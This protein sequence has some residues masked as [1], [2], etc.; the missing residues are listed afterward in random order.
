MSQT[1]RWQLCAVLMHWPFLPAPACDTSDGFCSA[2]GKAGAGSI[3]GIPS[4]LCATLRHGR[5]SLG[6]LHWAVL[7]T[8][9]QRPYWGLNTTKIVDAPGGNGAPKGT[10]HVLSQLPSPSCT[11][12]RAP[13][14]CTLLGKCQEVKKNCLERRKALKEVVITYGWTAPASPRAEGAAPR[15]PR[16]GSTARGMAW[17][18]WG[19]NRISVHCFYLELSC[20]PR[21]LGEV[22]VE[23]QQSRESSFH[24]CSQWNKVLP[25]PWRTACLLNLHIYATVAKLWWS[26]QVFTLEQ[27]WKTIWTIPGPVQSAGNSSRSFTRT[28][29]VVLSTQAPQLP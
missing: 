15:L 8:R 24:T 6:W 3:S 21:L 27:E 22:E 10:S 26:T 5:R 18:K 9:Q 13:S 2:I 29:P 12:L 7:Q 1:Q 25:T 17:T 11:A 4:P 14:G 23:L 16:E 20:F 19:K 28:W